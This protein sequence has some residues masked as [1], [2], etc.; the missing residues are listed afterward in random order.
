MI[1]YSFRYQEFRVSWRKNK[2]W[3]EIFICNF[4]YFFCFLKFYCIS[5]E[6]EFLFW[7]ESNLGMNGRVW[8]QLGNLV[9]IQQ[10]HRR[11]QLQLIQVFHWILKFW[12]G[13]H[14]HLLENELSIWWIKWLIL[15]QTLTRTL[16]T[17][18]LNTDIG[19]T[20][21]SC[22]KYT[23]TNTVGNNWNSNPS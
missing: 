18:G 19:C 12:E 23:F 15:N 11:K 21:I 2:S 7:F 3:R 10:Q 16:S 1:K 20:N 5:I 9:H 14:C 4:L 6:S 22:S 8:K 13:H 17:L